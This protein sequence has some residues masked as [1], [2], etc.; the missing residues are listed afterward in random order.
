MADGL[1]SNLELEWKATD[2]DIVWIGTIWIGTM[3]IQV[4]N[5]SVVNVLY[6]QILRQ[7]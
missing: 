5:A 6:Q 1:V 3:A 2:S 7:W 4:V